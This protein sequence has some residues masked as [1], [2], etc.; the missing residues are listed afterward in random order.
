MILDEEKLKRNM[1]LT[2]CKSKET[3]GN[4]FKVY[5][6][7]DLF[8]SVTSRFAESSPLDAAW[9]IYNFSLN[10]E[11]N[12]PKRFLFASARNTQKTLMLAAVEMAIILHD[13]RST[14]HFAATK[15]QVQNAH[16]YFAE[17][18]RRRYISDLLD[19][20]PTSTEVRFY[21]PRYDDKL[22]LEGKTGAE[23]NQINPDIVRKVNFE[24]LPITPYTVQGRHLSCVTVDETHT[25]KGEKLSAYADIQRI[26][27]ASQDG[28]P[29]VKFEISSRKSPHSI[30]ERQIANAKDTGIIVRKWTVLEGT[31]RCSD[32]R[33]GTDFV[34]VRFVNPLDGTII[35]QEEYEQLRFSNGRKANEYSKTTFA[36]KCLTCPIASICMGDL[37]KPKATNKH[38]QSIDTVIADYVGSDRGWFLAQCM[39]MQPAKEGMVFPTYDPE[40]HYIKPERMYE[41]FKGE[42][43]NF[44]VTPE[45]LAGMFRSAGLKCGLGLDWGFT[46]PFAVTLHFYDKERCFTI[47]SFAKSGMEV[48]KDVVP[49]LRNLERRF[50]KFTIYPDT[51]RPDN[52]SVLVREKFTI[53]DEFDK[54][55]DASIEIMRDKLK[56]SSGMVSWYLLDSECSQLN[57]EMGIYHYEQGPDGKFT[58]EIFKEDDDVVD[59]AR[60]FFLNVFERT[61]G[62]KMSIH[63]KRDERSER[64]LVTP[65]NVIRQQLNRLVGPLPTSG[66]NTTGK[67]GSFTFS[68]GSEDEGG[69]DDGGII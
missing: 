43:P 45:Y 49:F 54:D 42:K 60:Y 36:S 59:S 47:Y 31:E 16:K 57:D 27:T 58:D 26:P 1:L 13:R 11:Q 21:I 35:T 39:S 4:W 37:K 8:S 18:C 55:T 15:V 51:A 68:F 7:V 40:I 69:D 23:I 20:D 10:P 56:S 53:V 19:G 28:K 41:M 2:P 44:T 61:G 29:Y 46:H 14:L 62:I 30:V 24:V 33:S 3:L 52:N 9:E 66:G 17:F 22:W 34:H 67:S 25:L 48:N 50:G 65:D 64:N 6:G 38:L 63:S 32:E 5:L 12:I